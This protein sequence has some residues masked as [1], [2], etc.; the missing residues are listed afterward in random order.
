MQPYKS[1]Q[2]SR[3]EKW[4]EETEKNNERFKQFWRESDE[5]VDAQSQLDELAEKEDNI[6]AEV[7]RIMLR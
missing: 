5:F 1:T 6:V 3:Y 4:K 7:H 2:L